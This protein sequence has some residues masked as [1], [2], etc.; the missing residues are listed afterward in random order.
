MSQNSNYQEACRT[1]EIKNGQMKH[2]EVNGKEIA[3]ANLEGKFYAF[4][5]RCGYMNARLSNG[6]IK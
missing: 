4:A 1:S 5:E 2:V 3:I 6:S